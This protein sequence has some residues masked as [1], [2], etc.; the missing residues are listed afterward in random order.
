MVHAV[1]LRCLVGDESD[2]R[3]PILFF[4][5]DDPFQHRFHGDILT[6]RPASYLQKDPVEKLIVERMID[7]SSME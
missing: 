1:P 2:E 7:L 3:F 5:L 4:Y 6:T